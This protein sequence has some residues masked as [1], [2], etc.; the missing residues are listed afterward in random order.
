VVDVENQ[1]STL[2]ASVNVHFEGE[3]FTKTQVIIASDAFSTTEQVEL[4]YAD[5][6]YYKACDQ[7]GASFV[8]G[9][10]SMVEELPVGAVLL[11]VGCEKAEIVTAV[12][13]DS[14]IIANGSLTAVG[15]FIDG[16]GKVFT[17]KME[18]PFEKTI[19][20]MGEQ[21]DT[22]EITCV[23]SKATAKILSLTEVN[24]ESELTFTVYPCE[25]DSVRFVKEI[26]CSGEKKQNASAISVFI[27]M[28]GED[29]W[30]LSKRLNVCP[31]TLVLTN[32]DLHKCKHNIHNFPFFHKR[33]L[34]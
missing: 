4:T 24:L 28:E 12:K 17:R 7:Y 13:G 27:P 11:A 33:L 1:T 22:V 8:C 25:R 10:K 30:S 31:E 32:K 20:Y 3:A 29:L 21:K 5:F 23:A 26:K 16:E 19:E 14:G 2:T 6:P 34:L 15:Y 18:T 9:G